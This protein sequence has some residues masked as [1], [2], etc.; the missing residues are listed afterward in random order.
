MRHM[1]CFCIRIFAFFLFCIAAGCGGNSETSGATNA[2]FIAKSTVAR[3]TNPQVS[4][5]DFAAVVEGN[6]DFALKAFP[7]STRA[8]EPIPPSLP[9]ASLRHLPR[10]RPGQTGNTLSGIENALSFTLPQ[11]RLNPAFNKLD[12]L[13]A[14]ETSGAVQGNAVQLPQLNIVNALWAQEGFSI[15]PAYLE[16]IALNYGTG[17]HLLDFINA[18]EE[19]RLTMNSWVEAR[20]TAGYRICSRKV[21]FLPL[22]G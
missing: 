21:P 14:T 16:T 9:T 6:T 13:L 3:D 4:D 19:S 20:R 10:Q 12:L 11:D 15:L 1:S 5:T 8:T 22:P 2:G 18:T 7:C 17:L